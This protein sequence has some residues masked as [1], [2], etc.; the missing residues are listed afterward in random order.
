MSDHT[1]EHAR[2]LIVISVVKE[3]GL[4]TLLQV[5]F[6]VLVGSLISNVV[7]LLLWPQR[8]TDNL[9]NNMTETLNSFSTIL[10]TLTDIFLLEEPLHRLSYDKL[11]QA[12]DRHQAS[13]T[14]LKKNLE[15]AQSEKFFGGPGR[16][17]GESDGARR[18]ESGQAYEDAI[19]S[20]NRLGQHLNGLRSGI[21]I[22]RCCPRCPASK[23]P[24]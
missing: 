19:D 6:I 10:T 7:C 9:K 12:I 24:E 20:L 16:P 22:L 15:E 3:G 18:L 1:S 14:S 8:A 11:Q 17:S 2:K 23:R 13:F 5:S 4:E 21:P